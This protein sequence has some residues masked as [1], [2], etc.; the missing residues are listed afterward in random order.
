[1]NF[2]KIGYFFAVIFLLSLLLPEFVF[3]LAYPDICNQGEREINNALQEIES[4]NDSYT[5]IQKIANFTVNNYY[6]TYGDSPIGYL[7]FGGY[8][9]Q[10]LNTSIFPERFPIY[11]KIPQNISQRPDI[12]PI[13]LIFTGNPHFVA[14]Y[15]TGACGELAE[16]FN[17]V[18]TK[19]GIKSRIVVSS[20]EDHAWNEI[21]IENRWIHVDPTIYYHWYNNTSNCSNY[22]DFWYDNP[23]VYFKELRWHGGYSYVH[24]S[25]TNEDLTEKYCDYETLT[26]DFP[27]DCNRIRII[28]YHGNIELFNKEIN[29]SSSISINLGKNKDYNLVVE[30]D[31]IPFFAFKEGKSNFTLTESH[32]IEV[33]PEELKP[34]LVSQLIILFF[35]L[36][37]LIVAIN[38]SISQWKQI[39]Q[40]YL[41][42]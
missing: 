25:G 6:Q 26:I 20:A 28:K 37:F 23:Q 42:K 14:Y 29:S 3:I 33:T 27:I 8:Y 21:F 13:S 4:E 31:L 5:K 38:F 7:D 41:K 10:I 32:R 17:L 36:F 30:K 2:S 12:R 40:K 16:Y 24:V 18:L 39:Y 34:T 15:K 35:S 19:A 22:I 9:N 1:M 11:G